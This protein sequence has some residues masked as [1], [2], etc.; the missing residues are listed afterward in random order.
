MT[1]IHFTEY[2]HFPPSLLPSERLRRRHLSQALEHTLDRVKVLGNASSY[3]HTGCVNALSW[4]RNGEL[5]LSGGDDT[6]V[7][8][9]AIDASDSSEE[10][11]F[12][13]R[14]VIHT[15]HQANIFS[16]QMLPYS[17]RI[18]TVA[19]DKQVRVFDIGEA[20]FCGAPID[21]EASYDARQSCTHILRC[22]DD[23]VKKIVTEHS[24]DLFL[25]VGEDG[26]V[27]QHDLRTPHDCR[28]GPC[29]SP[30]VNVNHELSTLALS[31]LTPYQ[32][33]VAGRSPYGYLFDRRHVGRD[34]REEWGIPQPT[35]D[36]NSLT[37]CVRRFGKRK[38]PSCERWDRRP[39]HITGARMSIYNGHE[40]VLSFSGDAV[41]LYSTYDDPETEEAFPSSSTPSLLPS[42]TK[43]RRIDELRMANIT[44]L[45]D[46]GR[47]DVDEDSS[48]TTL[49][50]SPNI[51]EGSDNEDS[52]D[53][54]EGGGD[55][56]DDEEEEEEGYLYQEANEEDFHPHVPVILPRRRY[57]GARNVATVKDVNFLGPS[58]E[59]V[60]SG[61][62]DGNFFIWRKATEALH[63]IY[64]GDSTVVNMVESHPC[65]PLVA[66]SGIDHTIKIFAPARGPSQFSKIQNAQR[67]MEVN[68]RSSRPRMVGHSFAALLAE[69]RVAMAADG[70][71]PE[72]RTQ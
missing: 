43:R 60:V 50:A 67:I 45:Q 36:A 14:S 64:E 37:T 15:G 54:E 55:S 30:L 69:A 57:T 62:D 16:T 29:P 48:S 63:G 41:Y 28:G 66:V 23:R 68:A 18:A 1:I 25:T 32:F 61:S 20:A 5:L 13:C 31:P 12:V 11:P 4:A 53:E 33:V 46:T 58:D 19:G 72:C 38:K 47:M 26:T 8:I 59:Y 24:P 52:N 2:T 6:T 51:S 49:D 9:W 65:L 40:V 7:R 42:N 3:G 21:R 71:G 70:A 44:D 56:D 35:D 34:L 10:Y 27:R 17:S 39:E 22:H